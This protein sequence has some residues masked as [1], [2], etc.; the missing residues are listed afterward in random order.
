MKTSLYDVLHTA[1]YLFSCNLF[2]TVFD[3]IISIHGGFSDN[4]IKIGGA[5]I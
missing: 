2:T 1:Y 4:N 5:A 3:F